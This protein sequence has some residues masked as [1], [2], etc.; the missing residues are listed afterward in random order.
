MSAVGTLRSFQVRLRS[1]RRRDHLANCPASQDEQQHTE[2]EVL[3]VCAVSAGLVSL[4]Q[5]LR[6]VAP[7]REAKHEQ[8][9][10][11]KRNVELKMKRDTK[12]E[13]E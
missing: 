3:V 9:N 11:H 8:S 10:G 12:A 6:P 1:R 2:I 4:L 7:Q 13:T 5:V